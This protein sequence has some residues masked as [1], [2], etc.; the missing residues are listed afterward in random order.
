LVLKQKKA[1]IT[2]FVILGLVL[3][4]VFVI[5]LATARNASKSKA[6]GA[7]KIINELETG[8]IM[9]HVVS[10]M[11]QVALDGLE[12][13][14]NNGG[15]IYD[16]EGGTIPFLGKLLGVDYL[17]YSDAINAFFVAYGLKPNM[18]CNQIDYTIIKYPYYDVSLNT[19][20]SI[21]NTNCL[22]NS[23]Y[24]AFDGFYGENTMNKLCYVAKE[25]GC[26]GFAKGV[27]MGTTIQKQLEDYVAKKLPLCINFSSFTDQMPVDITPESNASVDVFV[28]DSEILLLLKYPLRISFENQEP[29]T[30]ILDYQATL[31]VRLGG[32][33]NFLYSVLSIDSKK[34]DFNLSREFI[35]S[36]EWR[37]G[38]ELRRISSP[39]PACALPYKH[40]DVIEVKD[41]KSTVKGRPFAFRVAVKDRMPALDKIYDPQQL[42]LD[43]KT[44]SSVDIP[45]KGYDPDDSQMN[46][47]F[48]SLGPLTANGWRENDPIII[49]N[50]K[51]GVLKF[52]ISRL[53]VGDHEV[54]II[55]IDD[56]GLFDLQW[57]WINISDTTTNNAPDSIPNCVHEC[58][59]EA[60]WNYAISNANCR[61]YCSLQVGSIQ[62]D[63][64]TCP[65]TSFPIDQNPYLDCW[66][67]WCKTA[68]NEC[69]PEC[70]TTGYVG[71]ACYPANNPS[72]AA[73]QNCVYPIVHAGDRQP[74]VDCTTITSKAIC[75]S[76][77]PDCFWIKENISD[78]FVESCYNDTMLSAASVPAY[79]LTI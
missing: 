77:M 53:D 46:Y 16:F 45:L 4:V 2:M 42:V 12:K 54:G 41:S 49:T 63:P 9:N 51:S 55:A 79:I 17:N 20:N 47:F 33:Y 70:A 37:D 6:A 28:H 18:N 59:V 75:L 26:E 67:A 1:Q 66:N 23:F 11:E 61:A 34:I 19:L 36:S 60:C 32:L 22:Y 68:A 5:L 35:S 58:V 57:F 25:S 62:C 15:V 76:N 31:K 10:C 14:G 13:I 39:C 38:F 8:R 74:H 30:K 50:L 64:T 78:V 40:D 3:L 43:V 69:R 7:E 48:L 71:W 72:L 52:P 29:I 24:S 27:I 73:C 65:L 21:Y 44:S 56:S